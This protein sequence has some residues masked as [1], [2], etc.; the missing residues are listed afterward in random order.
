MSASMGAFSPLLVLCV[1]Y[2]VLAD[3]T[4][5]PLFY[6]RSKVSV[7]VKVF[8]VKDDTSKY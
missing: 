7:I 5:R 6:Q 2:L 1:L 8:D 3:I 4:N